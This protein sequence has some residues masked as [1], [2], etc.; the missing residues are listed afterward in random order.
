MHDKLIIYYNMLKLIY[1]K[2][3][4]KGNRIRS[5]FINQSRLPGDHGWKSKIIIIIKWLPLSILERD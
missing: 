5:V 2:F 3:V 4:V 1:Y